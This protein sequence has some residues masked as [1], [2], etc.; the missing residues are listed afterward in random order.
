MVKN[1]GD[2]SGIAD[3]HNARHMMALVSFFVNDLNKKTRFVG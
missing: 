1:G 2:V 3:L